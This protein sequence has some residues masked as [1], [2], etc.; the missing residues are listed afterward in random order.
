MIAEQRGK[1][2]A[3]TGFSADSLRVEQ[4]QRTSGRFTAEWQL[5]GVGYWNFLFSGQG[6]KP[7]KGAPIRKILKWVRQRGIQFR[8][9]R[10]RFMSFNRT[11]YLINRKI[12]MLGTEIF[13]T[14]SKGVN[15]EKIVDRHIS[16]LSSDVASSIVQEYEKELNKIII[17]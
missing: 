5:V 4:Q 12:A 17:S 16:K 2:I 3:N 7:G 15:L 14:P 13:Q 6:R 11:A 9:D 1:G 10:G 8:D